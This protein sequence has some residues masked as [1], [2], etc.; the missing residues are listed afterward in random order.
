M[1]EK[2]DLEQNADLTGGLFVKKGVIQADVDQK[3]QLVV[4]KRQLKKVKLDG[5]FNGRNKII[6]GKDGKLF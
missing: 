6:F 4:S 3:P 2:Q 1:R 5:H